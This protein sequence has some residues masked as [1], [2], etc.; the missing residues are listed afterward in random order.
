MHHR[1]SEARS[2]YVMMHGKKKDGKKKGGG[3]KAGSRRGSSCQAQ[4]LW[5]NVF[6]EIWLKENV[7]LMPLFQEWARG[8]SFLRS[9]NKYLCSL[10]CCKDTGYIHT[11]HKGMSCEHRELCSF[12]NLR[13]L[14]L[15]AELAQRLC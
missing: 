1:A 6:L 3:G 4:D 14:P 8:L 9:R 11:I 15:P 10:S 13:L 7:R 5:R 12:H 2:L